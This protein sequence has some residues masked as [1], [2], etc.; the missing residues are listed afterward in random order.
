M[1][2]LRR[3]T[4]FTLVELLVAV[5]LGVLLCGVAMRLLLGEVRHGEAAHGLELGQRHLAAR[6]VRGGCS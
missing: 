1:P 4:G 2:E 5:G 3:R 6:G